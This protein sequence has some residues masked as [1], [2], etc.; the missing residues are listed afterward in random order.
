MAVGPSAQ[1]TGTAHATFSVTKTGS[2]V[3]AVIEY[4]ASNPLVTGAPNIDARGE[5]TFVVG[6]DELTLDATITGDQFPACES[7]VEDK[8]GKKIFVGGFAPSKKGQLGRLFGSMN[9]PKKIWFDSHVV[10]TVDAYGSFLDITGGGSGSNLTGPACEMVAM[11]VNAWNVRIMG[12]IPMP[13][14]AP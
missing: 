4:A 2:S 11:S 9:K 8:L 12:S 7:F 6:A 14:D 1:A 3:L 5:F 10:L 13:A